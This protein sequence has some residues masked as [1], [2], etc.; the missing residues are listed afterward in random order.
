ML[1]KTYSETSLSFA[2]FLSAAAWGMY[3]FPLRL[4][5]SVGISSSWSVVIINACPMILLIPLFLFTFKNLKLKLKPLFFSALMIGL[6][7][8]L[9][10]NALVETTV[11]RATLLFYLNPILGTVIG[12]IYLSEQV[13]KARLISIFIAMVG[14][15]LLLSESESSTYP[16]NIGDFY[17]LLSGLFWVLGAT[18][19]KQAES[20]PIIPLTTLIYG[21]TTLF[22]IFFASIIYADI[23]PSISLILTILPSSLFWSVIVFL[24]SFMI[25]FK[26]SQYLFPGRVGLLMMS[27][28]IVA[29]V[30]AS[31]L[32]PSETMILRQWFGAIAIVGAG[33]I[34]VSFSFKQENQ[35][36][37][38]P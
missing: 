18:S 14:L 25:I 6:A 29:I 7:I 16:L 22:S 24:P 13:T 28:V 5:E 36:S 21:S 15:V 10:A 4:I 30:S 20:I 35:I 2:T 31:L 12:L 27:E 1:T 38:Q 37:E 11:I 8:T 26:V 19:L 9:Y 33:V 23:T 34:E 3:W 32:L 17:G